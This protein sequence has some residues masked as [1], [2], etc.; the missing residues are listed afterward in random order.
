MFVWGLLL[1][2]ADKVRGVCLYQEATEANKM[3]D[4]EEGQQASS[5]GHQPEKRKRGRPRKPKSDQVGQY[6]Y[7]Y[8][9]TDLF[10]LL[11]F[12]IFDIC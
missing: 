7:I 3:A 10:L 12:L 5:G 1:E 8:I 4:M 6:I 2:K 9:F 11:I